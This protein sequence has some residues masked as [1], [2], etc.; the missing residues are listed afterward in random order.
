MVMY[1]YSMNSNCAI[2]HTSI[3]TDVGTAVLSCCNLCIEFIEADSPTELLY[4]AAECDFDIVLAA[5]SLTVHRGP[6]LL[7]K[8]I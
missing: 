8:K 1:S 3:N 4:N 5:G 7:S 6:I 2:K